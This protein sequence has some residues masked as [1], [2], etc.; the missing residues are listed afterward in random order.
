MILHLSHRLG[1]E[2]VA[3]IYE[4][5]NAEPVFVPHLVQVLGDVQVAA[6]QMCPKEE[7]LTEKLHLVHLAF[8]VQVGLDNLCPTILPFGLGL[9]HLVHA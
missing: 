4:W 8:E 9:L 6:F 3:A 7:P 5:F 2:Q 1:E